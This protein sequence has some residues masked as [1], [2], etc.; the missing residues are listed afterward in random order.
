VRT[1]GIA[2]Y[3]ASPG[4]DRALPGQSVQAE[5]GGLIRLLGSDLLPD[6]LRPGDTV[7]VHLYWQAL[8]PI[9][10]RYTAFVHLLG[11][12]NPSTGNPLWAQDDHQPGSETYPTDFWLPGEIV[13]DAFQFTVPGDAPAGE[14]VV[15]TGFYKLE[16][17]QRLGRSDNQ[18]DTAMLSRTIV[19]P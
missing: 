9:G 1:E 16:T 19:T 11:P 7:R 4:A 14:Y 3:R 8:T 2:T 13:L 6:V 12:T 17:G 5:F 15:T 10:E 18:G